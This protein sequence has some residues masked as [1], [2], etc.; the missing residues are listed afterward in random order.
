MPLRALDSLFWVLLCAE[1]LGGAGAQA[2]EYALL[3]M[4]GLGYQEAAAR[5]ES[6]VLHAH[7]RRRHEPRLTEVCMRTRARSAQEGAAC[8]GDRG[9]CTPGWDI[10]G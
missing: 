3:D 5:A 2:S 4:R 6:E 1:P 7:R 9:E 10:P 8:S